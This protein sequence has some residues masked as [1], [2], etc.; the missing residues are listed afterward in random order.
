MY[1]RPAICACAKIYVTKG[2]LKIS[3]RIRYLY[4][5]LSV[6]GS[7]AGPCNTRLPIRRG[8]GGAIA[9]FKCTFSSEFEFTPLILASKSDFSSDSHPLFVKKKIFSHPLFQSLHTGLLSPTCQPIKQ[10]FFLMGLFYGLTQVHRQKAK[11]S[12]R[13]GWHQ[14]L[15]I[16]GIKDIN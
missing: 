1:W 16:F 6:S 9:L 2:I 15:L 3:F 10:I 5:P 11:L 8:C 12:T 13:S 14:S 7:G 4:R